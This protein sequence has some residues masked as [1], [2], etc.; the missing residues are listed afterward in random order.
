MKTLY[1]RIL[2]TLI[3]ILYTNIIN[4]Y[5]VVRSH[6]IKPRQHSQ[7][8]NEPV[9]NIWQNNPFNLREC[10]DWVGNIKSNNGFENFD[11]LSNG[12][13]AGLINLKHYKGFT[14]KKAINIYAPKGD[15]LNDPV[16]YIKNI[17]RLSGLN[18]T[19]IITDHNLIDLAYAMII[20]ETGLIIEKT[21]LIY[22][23]T[24]NNI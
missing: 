8:I 14:I 17:K 1:K 9:I 3:F 22:I 13:R 11:S 24:T 20:C 18:E 6:P 19:D 4:D 16:I 12:I 7:V 10:C 5:K 2:I 15:G 23:K 21:F